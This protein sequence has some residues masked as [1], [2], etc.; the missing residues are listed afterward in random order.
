M[1][2][3]IGM[4]LQASNAF[5]NLPADRYGI[6]MLRMD[7]KEIIRIL[8]QPAE[9]GAKKRTQREISEELGVGQS[10]VSKWESGAQLPNFAESQKLRAFAIQKG[11]LTETKHDL[12]TH[13]AVK[14]VGAVGLGEE[15]DW[16]SQGD[17]VSLEVVEL[18]FPVPDGCFALEARGMSMHPRVKD[19]EIVVARANGHTADDLLGQEV[20][21]RTEEGSYLLKTIRRGF[22]PG[23]YNL[24]SHNGPL[25]EDEAVVWVAEIWAIIPSRKWVRVG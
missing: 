22:T 4:E 3:R 14:V 8:R 1:P 20:V 23:R 21:L 10:T 18:P 2:S 17:G 12:T 15:I 5:R 25:R 24:E 16:Y 7:V 19:G 11:I 9:P 6:P 13:R